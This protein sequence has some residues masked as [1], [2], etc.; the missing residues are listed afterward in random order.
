M[1]SVFF[2]ASS[3]KKIVYEPDGPTIDSLELKIKR[4]EA[5]LPKLEQARAPSL[6]FTRRE[7]DLTR[8]ALAYEHYC[9]N[10]ELDLAKE[11]IE[12]RLK[13]AEKRKD[14][15]SLTFYNEMKHRVTRDIKIQRIKYQ[16]LFEKEKNF[17][18]EFYSYVKQENIEAYTRA[19]RMTELA[20]NHAMEQQLDNTVDFLNRYK[21]YIDAIIF[22]H[23]SD[24]DLYKLTRFESAFKDIFVPLIGSDSLDAINEAENLVEY[25]YHY[26]QNTKSLL[27]TVYFARQRI[28]VATATSDYIARQGI[29]E[30]LARLTD[31]AIEIK[32][33]SVNPIGVY[34]WKEY[35]VVIDTFT[36]T[37]SLGAI[38]RGEAQLRADR[39]LSRYLWLKRTWYLKTWREAWHCFFAAIFSR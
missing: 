25:C 29:N 3:Q 15:Y 19:K 26:A 36:P 23:E 33:D 31:K 20:L 13:K 14:N 10:E 11:Q 16:A 34:K 9:F 27:D 7:L 18:K 4:L 2:C 35:I 17:K 6:F 5:E 30:E 8:F 38:K 21:S 1:A 12:D 22:D 28:A 32:P 24:Y 37:T 39:V